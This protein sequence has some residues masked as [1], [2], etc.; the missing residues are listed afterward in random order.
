MILEIEEKRKTLLQ[1]DDPIDVIDF[2]TGRTQLKTVGNVA[3]TS[4]SQSKFSNFLRLLCDYLEIK[5][6][7]ETGAS[8]GI[9]SLYL[10]QGRTVE[11]VVSIEGSDIIYRLAKDTTSNSGNIQLLSGNLYDLF[12]STLVLHEPD[13]IFLDADHRKSAIDFCLDK[14]Q[15]HC[16]NIKCIVIHDIYW[17]KDMASAWQEIIRSKSYNLTIDIFQAGIIFPNHPMEKQHF[18]LRF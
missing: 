11:K 2:K 9:N 16:R 12:E 15:Q 3:R 8:L 6:A 14:I 4:L 7:L 13:L 5:T 10:S 1:N 18:T 17:S